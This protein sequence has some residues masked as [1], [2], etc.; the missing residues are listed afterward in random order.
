MYKNITYKKYNQRYNLKNNK[1][2]EKDGF[3]SSIFFLVFEKINLSKNYKRKVRQEVYYILKYGIKSHIKKRNIN[4]SCD[5]YLSMLLGKINYVLTV[6]P[7]D[8]EFINYKNEIKH[9]KN[10]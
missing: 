7:N 8:K 3:F 1:Y 4:L 2:T 6:N 5:R 10:N 9:I